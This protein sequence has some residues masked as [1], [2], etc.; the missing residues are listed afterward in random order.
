VT[1]DW[2]RPLTREHTFSTGRT[3]LLR[4]SLPMSELLRTGVWDNELAA[5]FDQAISGSLSED[6]VELAV[7][8]NDSIV[9]GMF[10]EP[11]IVLDGADADA[12][13]FPIGALEE[14]EINETISAAFGGPA[15]DASFRGVASDGG[16]DA[17]G[18][19]VADDAVSDAGPGAGEPRSGRARPQGS[20]K[21]RRRRGVTSG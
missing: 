4:V 3:A 16:D 7:R 10:V 21:P 17:G 12:G 14:S 15:S 19:D 8:L 18:A 2:S 20:A 5:A 6:D 11:R 9:V 1:S 13:T